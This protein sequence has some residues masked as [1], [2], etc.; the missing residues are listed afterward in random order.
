MFGTK[1]S[2]CVDAVPYL[3]DVHTQGSRNDHESRCR[4]TNSAQCAIKSGLVLSV[5]QLQPSQLRTVLHKMSAG[6]TAPYGK[7]SMNKMQC[8][9][10]G[11][12]V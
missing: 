4:W 3:V 6:A 12:F 7:T 1:N 9:Q 10:R 11:L 8:C 5:S 2:T